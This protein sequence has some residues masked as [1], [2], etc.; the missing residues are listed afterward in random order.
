M[1]KYRHRQVGTLVIWILGLTVLVL[2][3]L[4]YFIEANPVGIAVLVI[5]LVCGALFWALT[6]EVTESDVVLTF[7]IGL[8]RKRFPLSSLVSARAVRNKWYF[9]WGIRLLDK[10]WLFNV[11]GL[12]AVEIETKDGSVHRI[13]TDQPSELVRVIRDACGLRD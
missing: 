10:G 12:D 1:I 6:V 11:S 4:L 5:L 13:G 3:L 2:G 8:I 7:G 9:G